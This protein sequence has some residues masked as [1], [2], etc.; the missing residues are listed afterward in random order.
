MSLSI[1]SSYP[2]MNHPLFSGLIR[3]VIEDN[4]ILAVYHYGSSVARG[5]FRDIDLCII[6]YNDEQ[7]AFFDKFLHYSGSYAAMGQ[8]PLDIT[9]FS[10][11]P[12]YIKIQII[13]KQ[14]NDISAMLYRYFCS[15]L[16]GDELIIL[17]KLSEH[18]LSPELCEII[19]HMN[20]F[21]NILVHGYT[22]LNDTLVY[23]NIFY[24]RADI[25]QFMEEVEDCIK[26]I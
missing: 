11:L 2:L 4:E 18:C 13:I 22:S 19:R 15:G 26:K 10:L 9:L 24:G 23:N 17:E 3:E 21:R 1:S 6:S 8:I 16:A 7:S 14:V 25:Y 12:L 5:D 20:G